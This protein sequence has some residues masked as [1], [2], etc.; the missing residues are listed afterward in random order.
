MF[1]SLGVVVRAFNPSAP[2][3]DTEAGG[4]VSLVYTGVIV[5]QG[6]KED[7]ASKPQQP[8]NPKQKSTPSGQDWR[9]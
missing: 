1:S 7:P 4:S 2:E 3:A 8:P 5:S 9:C 6:Y